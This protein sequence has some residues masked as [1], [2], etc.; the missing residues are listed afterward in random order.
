MR[1]RLTLLFLCIDGLGTVL[2]FTPRSHGALFPA[3]GA[4]AKRRLTPWQCVG[5]CGTSTGGAGTSGA[6]L[7]WIGHGVP[8]SL[9][10]VEARGSEAYISDSRDSVR[11]VMSLSPSLYLH[12]RR[13][14]MQLCLPLQY[15]YAPMENGMNRT[16]VSVQGMGDLTVDA[17]VKLG[18]RGQIVPHL[19]LSFPTGN[20]D[21]YNRFQVLP[22]DMQLGSGLFGGR[23]SLDYTIDRDW[24][25]VCISPSYTGGLLYMQTTDWRFDRSLYRGIPVR[26]TFAWARVSGATGGSSFCGARNDMGVVTADRITLAAYASVKHGWATHGFGVC[27]EISTGDD[28]YE[29]FSYQDWLK[30][31]DGQFVDTNACKDRAAAQTIANQSTTQGVDSAGYSVTT[32][33]YSNPTVVGRDSIYWKV[34]QSTRT[35]VRN[36]PLLSFQYSEEIALFRMP[37]FWGVVL[38]LT[39]GDGRNMFTGLSATVGTRFGV[40]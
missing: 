13:S 27:L 33:R 24:G 14:E 28:A 32:P 35:V 26:Q 8:G 4:S 7:R 18:T 17:S 1:N 25:S 31:S 6:T 39:L 30:S 38:P 21:A 29:N 20:F 16:G 19:G 11:A 22:P 9:L 12:L 15:R 36:Y 37:L 5:G 23:V 2:A 10:C 40:F 3:A 34:R